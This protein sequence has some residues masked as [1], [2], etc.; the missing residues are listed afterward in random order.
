MKSIFH[1][2]K[3]ITR[4]IAGVFKINNI[5][6]SHLVPSE[7]PPMP[8]AQKFFITQ[9]SRLAGIGL[10][11]TKNDKSIT[12]LK[13]AHKGER[14]FIIGNGPSLLNC[15][16]S[17]LK[18]EYTFGVNSIFLNYEN[19]G[20]HPTYY[21]VEDVYVGEDRAKEINQY[22]GPKYKFFG[23]YFKYCLN[24]NPD[25][26]WLNIRFRYDDYPGFPNFSTNAARQVWV[27]GTVTY[28]CLQLA[29]YMGFTEI[30]MIGFDHNYVIPDSAKVD[31]NLI[32]STHDDPNHF[33]PDYFGKGYRWHDPK[34][35]R[36]EKAFLRAK[37]VFE[38]D[39]RKI[40]NGTVGGNL[41]V[42]ERI[43]YSNL[44]GLDK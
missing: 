44:F 25:T 42:F 41:E 29:Y 43:E 15:D 9:R 21:V 28:I 33:H 22:T 32:I 20:F 19:M 38:A 40:F 11:V 18:D 23:N 6:D 4:K 26:L 37:Q 8:A 2:I 27:G 13:N 1:M 14:A 3:K 7:C 39:D 17:K 36:M 34:V 12:C 31:K 30:Y 16:L 5:I 24:N 35:D 10:P